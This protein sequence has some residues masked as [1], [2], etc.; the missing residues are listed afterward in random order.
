MVT[1]KTFPV[2]LSLFCIEYLDRCFVVDVANKTLVA[3][4][5]LHDVKKI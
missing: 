4:L 2:S 1:K 5:H 3:K